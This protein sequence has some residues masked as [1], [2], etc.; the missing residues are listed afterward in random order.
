MLANDEVPSRL[1]RMKQEVRRL[2]ASAV[3]G[4]RFALLAFAGRSYIL[5]PL[6]ADRGALQLFLENLDPSVV[7]QQ[8]T[9]I[10]RSIEQAIQLLDASPREGDRAIVVMSDGETFDDSSAALEAARRAGQLSIALVTVG[11]GTVAGSTIPLRTDSGVVH[12][13]DEQGKPVVTRY[14]PDQLRSIAH[15]AGGTFVDA[16]LPDKALAVRRVLAELV[17]SRRT[18]TVTAQLPP[19][20]QWFVAPVLVLLLVGEL[21]RSGARRTALGALLA[22]TWAGCTLPG[23]T[24]SAA[25]SYRRGD[26]VA[27][28]AAFRSAVVGGDHSAPALYNLGTALLAVD[29]LLAAEAA[30]GS[31]PLDAEEEIRYRAWY[32]V[33]LVQ[34]RRG[35]LERRRGD[36]GRA[37]EAL[38]AALASYK[39]VLLLRP[40]DRDA[41]WNY[42]LALRTKRQLHGGGGGSAGGSGGG[43]AGS[44][45]D[46]ASMRAIELLNNA[47]REERQVQ[48]R[49]QREA[50]AAA[51]PRT[52][53]W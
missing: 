24:V 26:Y 2:L 35:L 18:S 4:D 21:S 9:A 6:T 13:V 46:L 7:G 19:R 44:G 49:H 20:F 53:D 23:S 42:E 37:D 5:T 14:H 45:N 32:N 34:L 50:R 10:S 31:I 30:L 47:A 39:R 16:T 43:N 41:K 27:A 38:N 51:P 40:Y 25:S 28:L 36:E 11:F 48:A 33:G 22:G 3:S 17:R 29:S 8:G 12:K 1:E 52:R 15:A